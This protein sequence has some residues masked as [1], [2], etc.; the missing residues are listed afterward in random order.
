MDDGGGVPTDVEDPIGF[1]VPLCHVSS[2]QVETLRCCP[3]ARVPYNPQNH[4]SLEPESESEEFPVESTGIMMVSLTDSQEEE[5]TH[6]NSHEVFHTPPEES[7]AGS[8]NEIQPLKDVVETHAGG[9]RQNLQGTDGGCSETAA[10]GVGGSSE[11]YET[12]DLSRDSELG[13]LEVELAQRV[14]PP[15]DLNRLPLEVSGNGL[16][17]FKVLTR[18]PSLKDG[19]GESPMKKLKISEENRDKSGDELESER[20][21]PES[22]GSDSTEDGE[23]NGGES[24]GK[25]KLKFSQNDEV[26]DIVSENGAINDNDIGS[27]TKE[28]AVHNEKAPPPQSPLPPMPVP[29]RK[30]PSSILERLKDGDKEVP[31]REL[32][33]LELPGNSSTTGHDLSLSCLVDRVRFESWVRVPSLSPKSQVLGPDPGSKSRS[34]FGF[35]FESGVQVRGPGPGSMSRSGYGSGSQVQV[36]VW[37]PGLGLDTGFKSGFWVWVRVGDWC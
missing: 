21:T 2:S 37:V 5:N 20:D 6:S 3:L 13:F 19:L 14:Q 18:E 17:V 4:A 25:R 9:D 11:G 29:V 27:K 26:N 33:L 12:V 31:R 35:G 34:R 10:I 22:D 36:W 7:A 16:E 15:F 32:N 28:A 23:I 8:S 1:I 24:S 30:L